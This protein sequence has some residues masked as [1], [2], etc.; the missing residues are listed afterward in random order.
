MGETP[1]DG[2]GI[3][4]TV[5]PLSS[6]RIRE[7]VEQC[8]IC[9]RHSTCP[10]WAGLPV[11]VSAE[12]SADSALYVTAGFCVRTWGQLIP[13]PTM[14]RVLLRSSPRGADLPAADQRA[15]PPPVQSP[16]S[17]SLREMLTSGDGGG[18]ARGG[19]G[20]CRSPRDGRGGIGG[21]AK[22]TGMDAER[23]D[24]QRGRG[25]G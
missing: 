6:R 1:T 12:T 2:F 20:I 4:Y 21:Q 25:G 13:S 7:P 22:V 14:A 16:T 19:V 8:C 17:L 24:T 23:C 11:C 10:S 5:S 9:T 3:D 18:G 15:S